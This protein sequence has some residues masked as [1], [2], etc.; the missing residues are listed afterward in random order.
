MVLDWLTAVGLVSAL[1]AAFGIATVARCG[2]PDRQRIA[3][4]LPPRFR[5]LAAG[6]IRDYV[7]EYPGAAEVPRRRISDRLAAS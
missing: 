5:A 2:K 4:A 6:D 7:V 1:A 3:T